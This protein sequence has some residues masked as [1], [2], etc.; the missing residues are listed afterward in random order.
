MYYFN[1]LLINNL[2]LKIMKKLFLFAVVAV[3]AINSTNAQGQLNASISGGIPT[4]D[5]A[6]FTT[7]AIAV[8]L[9]YLFELSE[10]FSLGPVLGFNTSFLDSDFDG[11]NI[12]FLPIAASGRLNVSDDFTLGADIGYGVGISDGNDGGVYYSPSVLYGLTETLDLILAYRAFRENNSTL[13]QI[14]LG[15]VIV[16]SAAMEE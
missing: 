1:M 9:G 2:I 16:I 6:D 10:D 15:L 8:D 4:G 5:L 13:G 12:S 3:F 14:T 7:F 11:D